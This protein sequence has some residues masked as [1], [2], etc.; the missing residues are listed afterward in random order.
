MNKITKYFIF[1]I[2]IIQIS[3]ILH[4]EE[5]K[6]MNGGAYSKYV[7][8]ANLSPDNKYF[9]YF[10]G[11]FVK[12]Y[13]MTTERV[14]CNFVWK[15]YGTD[16]DKLSF[17]DNGNII[18]LGLK[19]VELWDLKE[20]KFLKEFSIK[21]NNSDFI[22]S[23]II[24][25]VYKDIIILSGYWSEDVNKANY[26]V[27]WDINKDIMLKSINMT[28]STFFIN[29][30]I[31]SNDGSLLYVDYSYQGENNEYKS[32]QIWNILDSSVT[33]DMSFSLNNPHFSFDNKF[34]V[35]GHSTFD[36]NFINTIDVETNEIKS[37]YKCN[38]I[39]IPNYIFSLS[40][41]ANKAA[42]VNNE[43]TDI[44]DIVDIMT[45]NV[46]KQVNSD[47][48]NTDQ[49]YFYN[50]DKELILSILYEHFFANRVNISN[51]QSVKSISV[52]QGDVIDI[53]FSKDGKYLAAFYQY[54]M[55]AIFETESGKLINY[56]YDPYQSYLKG[57]IEMSDDNTFVS[58]CVN[59]GAGFLIFNYIDG[60]YWNPSSSD[61]SFTNHASF[62]VSS[63]LLASG[64][65]SGEIQL[66]DLSTKSLF[67]SYNTGQPVYLLLF[68]EDLQSILAFTSS[69]DDRIEILSWDYYNN[70]IESIKK[71]SSIYYLTQD[72][73][74]SPNRRFIAF[75]SFVY[76][77]LENQSIAYQNLFW[78]ENVSVT[79]DG[80]YV[81]VTKS[82]SSEK[83]SVQL[84]DL[85]KSE[86]IKTFDIYDEIKCSDEFKSMDLGFKSVALSPNNKFLAAGFEDGTIVLWDLDSLI[87]DVTP[88]SNDN[89]DI[90]IYPN[91]VNDKIM[92]TTSE[93]LN[94]CEISLMNI[95]GETVAVYSCSE[96][97]Q[98]KPVMINTEILTSG[99]YFLKIQNCNKI[100]TEKIIIYR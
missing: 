82:E 46:E 17:T 9:A 24:K 2:L 45:G 35:G 37:K 86:V 81:A 53:K 59:Q 58:M 55:L 8:D 18:K 48:Y 71:F 28:D 7:T 13:N 31:V 11:N 92:I 90:T 98:Q 66:W 94:D 14:E 67:K 50:N 57:V 1:S 23:R 54:A 62:S 77:I 64:S 74:I 68:N 5:I 83:S 3:N 65:M 22:Y 6:W 26:V 47:Y 32:P 52:G 91:P 100:M 78:V 30:I 15:Y 76:D 95:L 84:Y 80:N 25:P 61:G 36:G 44:I 21:R 49:I 12:V 96:L 93:T 29:N 56:L 10:S 40:R 97:N 38:N 19:N 60:D 85:R 63:K 51:S 39:E 70:S 43:N 72:I 88:K 4:T 79:N 75:N 42:I 69:D 99:L 41:E 20:A 16:D 87:N 34:I 33:L 89:F 73:S 27:V